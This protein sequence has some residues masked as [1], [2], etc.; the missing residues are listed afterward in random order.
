MGCLAENICVVLKRSSYWIS[1]ENDREAEHTGSTRCTSCYQ[2][3]YWHLLLLHKAFCKCSLVI[4]VIYVTG[5][6]NSVPRPHLPQWWTYLQKLAK[7]FQKDKNKTTEDSF[8][9]VWLPLWDVCWEKSEYPII[10]G[11]VTQ[12]IQHL[13]VGLPVIN[14]IK[15][16][17]ASVCCHN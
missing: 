15:G 12:I 5:Y 2:L 7:F 11:E 16:Y 1:T 14:F 10:P 17:S 8:P 4:I 13:F 3:L 6:G 9:T